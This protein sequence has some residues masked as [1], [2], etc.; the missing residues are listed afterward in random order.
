MHLSLSSVDV[1]IVLFFTRQVDESLCMELK[2]TILTLL[3]ATGAREPS[4]WIACLGDVLSGAADITASVGDL[5]SERFIV[6][7]CNGESDCIW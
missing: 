2:D 5:L 7:A 4:R 1:M 3:A 6:S